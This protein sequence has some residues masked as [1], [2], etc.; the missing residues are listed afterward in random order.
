MARK[1]GATQVADNAPVPTLDELKKKLLAK[2][3]AQG[4]L[5]YE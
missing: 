5:S 2:G 4:S 3:K 1:K